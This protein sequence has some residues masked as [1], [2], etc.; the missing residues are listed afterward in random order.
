MIVSCYLSSA[1]A[2]S[3]TTQ[4]LA[5]ISYPTKTLATKTDV[6]WAFG[7]FICRHHTS[8]QVTFEFPA[9]LLNPQ[10][11]DADSSMMVDIVGYASTSTSP[12]K[13]IKRPL[14]PQRTTAPETVKTPTSTMK[15]LRLSPEEG[16]GRSTSP[17]KPGGDYFASVL[18]DSEEEEGEVTRDRSGEPWLTR[19]LQCTG[20]GG[21]YL[22]ASHC[23]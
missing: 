7:T 14:P 23:C 19:F 21:Q 13:R 16:S 3:H 22:T 20:V 4:S 18:T 1:F 10:K 2:S 9:Q 15:K 17:L 12:Q 8:I 11:D 6:P 5:N